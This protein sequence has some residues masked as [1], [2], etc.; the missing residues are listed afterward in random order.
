MKTTIN[1]W[2]PLKELKLSDWEEIEGSDGNLWQ[3]T[4]SEDP[5]NGDYT[6]LTKFLAGYNT[7]KFG[8][9]RHIYPEEVFVV[10][11]RLYDKAF[12]L[13][14]ETG[15]YA[16]RPAG[17]LHGPFIAENDVIILEMSYPSQSSII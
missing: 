15:H 5:Q 13:W 16:S 4:L 17:E 10:S 12:N 2:N 9:K 11:G 6:R 14:I 1:Y 8:A 3:L 7:E